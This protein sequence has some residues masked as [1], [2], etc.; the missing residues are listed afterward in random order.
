MLVLS[1]VHQTLHI[2]TCTLIVISGSPGILG[3]LNPHS[4]SDALPRVHQI[5]LICQPLEAVSSTYGI[6]FSPWLLCYLIYMQTVHRNGVLQDL[7]SQ[8]YMEKDLHASWAYFASF[9]CFLSLFIF[10]LEPFVILR[11]ISSAEIWAGDVFQ[12]FISALH[13]TIP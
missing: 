13:L 7:N 6:E 3:L 9:F 11:M 8:R 2:W 12:C 4:S 10:A 1:S 5:C